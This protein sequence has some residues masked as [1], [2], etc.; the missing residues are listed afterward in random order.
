MR[1]S[2]RN[3]SRNVPF[4]PF[5]EEDDVESWAAGLRSCAKLTRD[6]AEKMKRGVWPGNWRREVGMARLLDRM[7]EVAN[8]RK[9]TRKRANRLD[10]SPT[11]S[12]GKPSVVPRTC[13]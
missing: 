7:A 9:R 4:K 11:L 3:S 10:G 1:K 12:E 13:A 5:I 6:S 8:P 2:S